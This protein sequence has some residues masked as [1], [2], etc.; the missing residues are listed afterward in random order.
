MY[1]VERGLD[2]KTDTRYW[3][4]KTRPIFLV[5]SITFLGTRKKRLSA[6]MAVKKFS[7]II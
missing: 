7:I 1:I 4:W 2:V 3:Y 6:V 5:L